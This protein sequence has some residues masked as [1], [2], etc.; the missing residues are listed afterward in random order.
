MSK[1]NDISISIYKWVISKLLCDKWCVL[2]G[3]II[4]TLKPRQNKRHFPDGLFDGISW[5][6]IYEF[7][8]IYQWSLF[9]MDPINYIP[10]L[11][12]IMASR[13]PGNKPLSQPMMVIYWRIY[14]T[15]GLNCLT[16]I[17]NIRSNLTKETTKTFHDLPRCCGY[18]LFRDHIHFSTSPPGK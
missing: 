7:R 12:Q 1:Q 18:K 14:A 13:R 15:L 16:A 4:N 9:L 5:M 3:L 17:D 8:C 10:P 6:E 2:W 11:V